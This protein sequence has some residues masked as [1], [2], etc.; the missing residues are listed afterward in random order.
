[1]KNIEIRK[2]KNIEFDIIARLVVGQCKNPATH[3]IH[4]DTSDDYD[5]VYREITRLASRSEICF[6]AA[7]ENDQL[8]GTVGCEWD[9]E[10][11]RGWLRGPFVVAGSGDWD[12]ITAVLLQEIFSELP[13]AIHCL[14]TFLNVANEQG[15]HLYLANGFHQIRLI[16]VY[17]ALPPQKPFVFSS[18]C[19]SLSPQ[20]MKKFIALHDSIFPQ[21]H[22]TGERIVE[23]LDDDHR[24]FVVTD[25]D[26]LLGYLYAIIE[27]EMHEGF[28][29]YL[30]VRRDARGQGIGQQLLHT[31]LHWIFEAKKMSQAG[32]V[33]NDDL[34]NARSLYEKVGFELKYTG[35]HT[36][37]EW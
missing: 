12:E 3:C 26:E 18:S 10:T 37:K 36:R 13:S 30:G 33:V 34:T 15:N 2:M 25:D 28:V 24:V 11:G 29:D 32:L 35:V 20:Q 17:V 4:S 7:F 19:K 27:E 6:V 5:G 1:M 22:I 31:A 8:V 16:H 23:K 21:A 14:D 9:E